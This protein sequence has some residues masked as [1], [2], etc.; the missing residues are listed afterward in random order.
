M[1]YMPNL[2]NGYD[3]SEKEDIIIF[4]HRLAPEKQVEI[5]RDLAESLPQYKFVV[6]QDN[7]LTKHEYHK[8]LAKSKIMWSANLQETLGISPFEG[9]LLGVVPLLPDRLSYSEMY[10]EDYLYPSE[11]TESYDSYLKYKSWIIG[12]ITTTMRN[13]DIMRVDVKEKL[14]PQLLKEYFTAT[15]LTKQLLKE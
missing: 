6:C 4:P 13:Y 1:E 2:F 5:F 14:A 9:A 11:W 3:F 15:E 7:K 10:N 8:L 12:K